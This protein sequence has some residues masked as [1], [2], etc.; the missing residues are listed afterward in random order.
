MNNEN[1]KKS[2][3]KRIDCISLPVTDID[4]GIE[5]YKKLGHECIWREND[6]AAGLRMSDSDTEIVIHTKQLPMEME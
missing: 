5:F 2:L 4:S 6:T 3:F 1:N